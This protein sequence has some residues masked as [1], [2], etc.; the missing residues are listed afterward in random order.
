MSIDTKLQRNTTVQTTPA[1]LRWRIAVEGK[2]PKPLKLSE[3]ITTTPLKRKP[4][5]PNYQT[6]AQ[7]MLRFF[8][9]R[10]GVSGD[11]AKDVLQ[12]TF[13][14]IVR[15]AD[16]FSG[17]GTAKAWIWQVARNCLIDHQRKQM[18]IKHEIATAKA[19]P[20]RKAAEEGA[21]TSTRDGVKVTEY[22]YVKPT[23][24][25]MKGSLGEHETAVNDEQWARLEET[26]AAPV[27]GTPHAVDECVAA[28]LGQFS[29]R[30]PERAYVLMMQM[31][32]MSIDD[33]GQRIG[34]TVAAT[35][36]YLS[37]CKKK[38]QPYI[39]HCTELLAA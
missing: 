8:V 18:Q 11:E 35:K 14:K 2:L 1:H 24:D 3:R 16:S 32:G 28:G 6:T 7:P 38:I 22:P 31:D 27:S 12:E 26:T 21:K 34:R 19:N 30:E 37:Q 23:V 20:A 39:A 33:I 17:D 36:E 10:G 29:S 13:V 25:N 4:I 5:E 9:Y 15:S